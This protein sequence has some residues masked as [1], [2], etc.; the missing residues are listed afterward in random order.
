MRFQLFVIAIASCLYGCNPKE[1]CVEIKSDVRAISYVAETFP[2]L[3]YRTPT[4][5]E[6]DGH[7]YLCVFFDRGMGMAH[8]PKCS[9]MKKGWK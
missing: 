8:S 5:V 2:N 9:C 7:Q 6:I 1:G 4:Y 3:A